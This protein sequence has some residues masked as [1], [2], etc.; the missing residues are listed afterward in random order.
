MGGIVRAG[1]NQ[2]TGQEAGERREMVR[3]WAR[4]MRMGVHLQLECRVVEGVNLKDGE[5]AE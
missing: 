4:D 3:N 2:D 1:A 5:W